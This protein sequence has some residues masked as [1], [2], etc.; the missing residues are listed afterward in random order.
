MRIVK[1]MF[2]GADDAAGPFD[3]GISRLYVLLASFAILTR[4][5]F[6]DIVIITYSILT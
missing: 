2:L 6:A 3:G 5:F 4:F 1:A